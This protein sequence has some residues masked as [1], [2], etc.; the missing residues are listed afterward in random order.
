MPS[1]LIIIA[2]YLALM[3]IAGIFFSRN[4]KSTADYFL[5]AR[6]APWFWI[7][8]AVWATN[9][10]FLHGYLAHGGAAYEWGLIQANFEWFQGPFGYILTGLFFIA[11]YWRA[12]IFTVPH[13]LERRYG[14]AIRVIY[15][16]AW[17][18]IFVVTIA[19]ELY[20]GGM[21]LRRLLNLPFVP[22]VLVLTV[23]VGTYT[24]LGGLGAAIMMEFVQFVIMMAGT[25]PLMFILLHLVGGFEG[26]TDV[27]INQWGVS[28]QYFSVLPD[29]HH[30][31]GPGPWII[32]G[33]CF[34]VTIGWCAGHQSMVQRNLGARSLYDSKLGYVVAGVPKTLGAFLYVVPM[35]MAPII[36]AQRGIFVER[37]DAAYG[38]LILH[39]LP[40]G[41]LGLFIAGLVSAG[42]SSIG[43]VLNSSSTMLV[44][45]I[46]ERFFVKGKSDHHYFVM[47]RVATGLIIAASLALVPVVTKVYLIMWLEQMLI[48]MALGPFMGIL[49]LGIFWRRTNVLGGTLGFL[50]GGAFAVFMQQ[51]LGIQIFFQVSWWSFVVTLAATVVISLLTKRPKPEKVE[52]ITWESDFH[53]QVGAIAEMRAENGTTITELPEI[54]ITRPPWYLNL[55][56]WATAIL[57]VQ[58]VLLFFFG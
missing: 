28:P 37:S 51:V 46:Y 3:F 26:L 20:L 35:I 55:K 27:L 16:V 40:S 12:G 29:F 25:M 38:K 17:L 15:S 4:I 39:L 19:A 22:T 47:G 24:L 33:Q 18:I 32:L 30:P 34:V 13:F 44:K 23:V 52:G 36:F 49:I 8:G 42:L 54:T 53:A 11:F 31:Y 10:G 5:A 45:D 56:Y 43:S 58:L 6:S 48:A 9:I 7:M 57:A 1:D 14:S 2:I 41:M 50:I 21:F